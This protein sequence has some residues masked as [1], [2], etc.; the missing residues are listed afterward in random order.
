MPES[1]WN[2][3]TDAGS[4]FFIGYLIHYL[5]YFCADRTLFLHNYLP[6]FVFKLLLLCYVLDHCYFLIT[7]KL[8]SPFWK[9]AFELGLLFWLLIVIYVFLMFSTL[10]YGSRDLN[11][12]D[13]M[14]LRW[15]D[16]WDFIL[17]KGIA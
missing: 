16:T 9:L 2:R 13:I 4:V 1:E 11:V 14:Q 5:P 7:N 12:G 6:A 10:C 17:H 15:K 8:K 3:F